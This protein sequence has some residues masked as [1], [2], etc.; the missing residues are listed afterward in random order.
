[1]EHKSSVQGL[2]TF[3]KQRRLPRRLLAVWWAVVLGEPEKAQVGR[4]A[5]AFWAFQPC[6]FA[7]WILKP[8]LSVLS[9]SFDFICKLWCFS[10]VFLPEVQ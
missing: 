4:L 9:I 10:P 3:N 6:S 5:L 1:M 7:S 2:E 8:E